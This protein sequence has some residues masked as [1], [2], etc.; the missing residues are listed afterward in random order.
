MMNAM[1]MLQLLIVRIRMTSTF[2]PSRD[3]Y[4]DDDEDFAHDIVIESSDKYDLEQTIQ[5]SKK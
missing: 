2:F 5:C 4:N 1:L 3:Q